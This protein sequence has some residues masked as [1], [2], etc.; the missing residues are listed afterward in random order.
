M[1]EDNAKYSCCLCRKLQRNINTEKKL[2]VDK[3]IL[4]K[5]KNF[6]DGND[7]ETIKYDGC[8]MIYGGHSYIQNDK[9][10]SYYKCSI[11]KSCKGFGKILDNVFL[12][13]TKTHTCDPKSSLEVIRKQNEVA[14]EY[15]NQESAQVPYASGCFQTGDNEA[16]NKW[17]LH[18]E[19]YPPYFGITNTSEL[20]LANQQALKEAYAPGHL[21]GVPAV[22]IHE[23]QSEE[24]APTQTLELDLQDFG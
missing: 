21:A 7:A 10:T 22:K 20:Y 2:N 1:V 19:Q 6:I 9:K 15:I 16:L 17:Q 3:H 18:Q 11:E 12:P 4:N 5:H 24:H 13:S 23:G 14:Q 8:Y